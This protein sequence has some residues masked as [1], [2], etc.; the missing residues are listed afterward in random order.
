M[1]DAANTSTPRTP[2]TPDLVEE[3]FSEATATNEQP[4]LDPIEEWRKQEIAAVDKQIA[5]TAGLLDDRTAD[6]L[7][8]DAR[9]SLARALI[10]AR[11]RAAKAIQGIPA[12]KIVAI[13][14]GTEDADDAP[15]SI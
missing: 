5:F 3:L 14:T 4:P 12:K 7:D 1:T 9:A 6:S 10:T 8:L 13:L 11:R 2:A 15:A